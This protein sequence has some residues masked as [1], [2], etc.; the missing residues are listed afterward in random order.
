MALHLYIVPD[1]YITVQNSM[2]KSMLINKYFQTWILFG[3]QL[4]AS[5]SEARFENSK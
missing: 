4:A 5:Q 2:L 3:W 1:G